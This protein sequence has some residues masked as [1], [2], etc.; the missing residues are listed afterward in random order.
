M[1]AKV[2]ILV[3]KDSM[4]KLSV[5]NLSFLSI[6]LIAV[7]VGV[8]L[9]TYSGGNGPAR[10]LVYAA[11]TPDAKG[12]MIYYFRAS[13]NATGTWTSIGDLLYSSYI[14]GY[15]YSLPANQHT[16]LSVVVYLNYTLAP[17]LATASGRARIYLNISGVV[18]NFAMVYGSGINIGTTYWAL[19]Y[20]YPSVVTSP[21]TT[22]I[23]ATDTTYTVTLQYQAY[24]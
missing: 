8:I 2:T 20:Y 22:W 4:K 10:F 16:I 7:L 24:Y 3:V 9:A 13:Q 18:T 17:D 14:P 1:E 5:K 6:A 12:N 23:P 11:G 15:S 19:T 21:T